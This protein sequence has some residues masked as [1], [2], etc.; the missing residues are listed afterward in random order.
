[1]SKVWDSMGIFHF[2]NNWA[3]DGSCLHSGVKEFLLTQGVKNELSAS[4]RALLG[5]VFGLSSNAML[6]VNCRAPAHNYQSTFV[7][8]GGPDPPLK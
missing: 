7:S 6:C 2:N 1:M 8:H 4:F 5:P 3:Q